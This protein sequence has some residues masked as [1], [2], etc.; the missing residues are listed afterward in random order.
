[1]IAFRLFLLK[2]I[3]TVIAGVPQGVIYQKHLLWGSKSFNKIEINYLEVQIFGL[4][5]TKNGVQFCAL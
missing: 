2:S 5:E 1:M 4:G 3:Y